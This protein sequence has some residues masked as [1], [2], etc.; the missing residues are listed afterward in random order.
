[1]FN[2]LTHGGAADYTIPAN[3]P[4]DAPFVITDLDIDLSKGV[5]P[6]DYVYVDVWAIDLTNHEHYPLD[7]IQVKP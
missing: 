4:R 6:T 3:T 1:M 7:R 2:T 5:K